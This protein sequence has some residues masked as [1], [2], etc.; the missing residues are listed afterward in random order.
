M[1]YTAS[2]SILEKIERKLKSYYVMKNHG[3]DAVVPDQSDLEQ[4][5]KG[6]L[7]WQGFRVN[8]LAKLMRAE[9]EEWM[10]RVSGE[11]VSEDI[12]LVSEEEDVEHC[13]RIQLAEMMNSMFSG[14]MNVS[15]M[16]ELK[17]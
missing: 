14:Q 8:Y 12:V 17:V 4:Y 10:R 7:T 15:Y 13:Y 11:A 5:R 9:A 2:L 16:G 6:V 3:N 1:L